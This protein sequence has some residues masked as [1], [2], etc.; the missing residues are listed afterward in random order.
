MLSTKRGKRISNYTKNYV[1]FDL[2]TTGISWEYDNVI[3]ISAIRV[4]AGKAADEFTSLVNP[5][6]PIPFSAS[7]VN[8][9]TDSM[10]KDAPL[11]TDILLKFCDF[12]GN[13]V[14]VGHNIHSFDM[15]FL[16]R[17]AERFYGQT[18]DNN[19]IDTLLMARR[20]LPQLAHHRLGDLAA[21][22]GISAQGAHRA[23]NDCRM[24]H[25]VFEHLAKEQKSAGGNVLNLKTCPRCGL[26]M[27]KR[28]GRYGE[29]WGCSGYPGCR[30]T[31]N[32]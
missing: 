6:R 11:F 24:N 13:D 28:N 22:Y 14:L 21:H 2:E 9:I 20:C 23:L 26:A 8:G 1:V 32:I 25:Q 3:E 31:E 30:Y 5:G 15:K 10:V 12:A 19:Y 27:Q 4:R 17:D 16:Y 7:Q 18:L 29:F